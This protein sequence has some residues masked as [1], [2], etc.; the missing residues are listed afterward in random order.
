ML[1]L[2]TQ[3]I[4]CLWKKHIVNISTDASEKEKLAYMQAALKVL[5]EAKP[6]QSAPEILAEI[7]EL[8]K[9]HFGVVRD[10]L[11]EKIYFNDLMLQREKQLSEKLASAKQPLEL[12]MRYAMLGNYIDFA[13]L[14][15]VQEEK[16][17]SLIADAENINLNESELLH[18]QSDLQK[19]KR[20]V[21]LT[22]NCG[23]IVFDKL[24]VTTLLRLYPDIKAD[25]IVR[26]APVLNDATMQDAVQIGMDKIVHV[27]DNGTA[28]A[29]TCLDKISPAARKIIDAADVILAKGQGNFETLRGV[30][31]NIYYLFLCKCSLFAERF[32]VAQFTPMLLNDLRI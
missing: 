8:Q 4:D 9:R 25:V 7:E 12:A 26:G 2:S 3:C 31:K 14:D 11:K 30:K 1:R 20:V 32:G 6:S 16:L 10:F 15:A 5:A 21:I 29:G 27:I 13:A 23:E 22:D 19:A 18:L 28:I 24:L 17:E